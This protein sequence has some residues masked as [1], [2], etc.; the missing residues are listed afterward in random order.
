MSGTLPG[1]REGG[2]Q[3]G[4][5]AGA[6]PDEFNGLYLG[7]FKHRTGGN[8]VPHQAAGM[9][10]LRDR[11]S[12]HPGKPTVGPVNK[13]GKPKSLFSQALLGAIMPNASQV[14]S[15]SES[16]LLKAQTQVPRETISEDSGGWKEAMAV[17]NKYLLVFLSAVVW[18]W[19]GEQTPKGLMVS[20]LSVGDPLITRE[21]PVESVSNSESPSV[22]P[23]KMPQK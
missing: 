20:P 12:L 21:I 18:G 4:A 14:T 3:S 2:R 16:G 10:H 1:T 13:Q 23:Q 19:R 6:S 7:P 8:N 11:G 22:N 5:G 9:C 15:G 17:A